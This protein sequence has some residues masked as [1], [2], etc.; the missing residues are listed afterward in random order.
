MSWW[1]AANAKILPSWPAPASSSGPQDDAARFM[2]EQR[3]DKSGSAW[4][5]AQKGFGRR[6]ILV[7]KHPGGSNRDVDDERR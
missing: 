7:G 5:L 1:R 2:P 3:R 4:K 6:V